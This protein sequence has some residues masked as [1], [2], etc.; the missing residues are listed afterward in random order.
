M[1]VR[2]NRW[3]IL[4]FIAL[5]SVACGG[6]DDGDG[7]DG[8]DDTADGGDDGAGDDIAGDDGAGDGGAGDGDEADAGPVACTAQS[9]Q[10]CGN[11]IDDDL[12]GLIDGQDPQ[13]QGPEDRLEDSFATGIPGDNQ[14]PKKQECFFDGNSGQCQVHTC[15]LLSDCPDDLLPFDR[16]QDCDNLDAPCLSDCLPSTPVGCDCYGCC[17]VCNPETDDCADILLQGAPDECDPGDIGTATMSECLSC[18]K[19]EDCN[20]GECDGS[21]DDCILCPGQSGDDLPDTCEANECPEGQ[22]VCQTSDDCDGLD[23]C[24]NGC[25]RAGGVD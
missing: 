16:D 17:T 13:C 2:S 11:C 15:C 12:D 23:Y 19:V 3:I 5:V 24:S 1:R 14:D 4:T 25:C 21:P 8:G 22:T 10:A 7:A 6:D 9:E 20:G 18:V